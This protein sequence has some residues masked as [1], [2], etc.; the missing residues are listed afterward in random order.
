ML[1]NFWALFYVV[2]REHKNERIVGNN[3]LLKEFQARYDRLIIHFRISS[4]HSHSLSNWKVEGKV[5]KSN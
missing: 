1:F 3:R 4:S 2:G 5:F